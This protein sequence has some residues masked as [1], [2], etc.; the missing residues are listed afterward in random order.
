MPTSPCRP[1][2]PQFMH[3]NNLLITMVQLLKTFILQPHAGM[4]RMYYLFMLSEQQVNTPA[5]LEQ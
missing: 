4:L 2:A 1:G 3:I 5:K